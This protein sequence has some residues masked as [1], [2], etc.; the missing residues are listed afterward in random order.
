MHP[1]TLEGSHVRLVPLS[2][3]HAEAVARVAFD[4]R[5]WQWTTIRLATR[6]DVD[7]WLADALAL[8]ASLPLATTLR[9]TGDAT[10]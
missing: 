5:I 3:E 2:R 8:P 10:R 7:R 9:A 6:E 4:P 1:V